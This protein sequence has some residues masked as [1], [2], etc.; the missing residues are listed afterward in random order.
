MR[1][2]TW[3]FH[4]TGSSKSVVSLCFFRPLSAEVILNMTSK[5]MST[6][7]TKEQAQAI[8][9]SEIKQRVSND[10][11]QELIDKKIELEIGWMFFPSS[12]LEYPPN[13]FFSNEAVVVSKKGTVRFV[14]NY[15]KQE[16]KLKTYIVELTEH[17]K[18][19]NE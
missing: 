17:M 10:M 2:K 11:K 5:I 4:P 16:N 14:P 12:M 18:S 13:S 9:E 19:H 7:L 15:L 6:E 8:A 3:G 1:L